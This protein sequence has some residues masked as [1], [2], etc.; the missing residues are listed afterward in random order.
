MGIGQGTRQRLRQ[1]CA[2]WRAGWPR[3]RAP[4]ATTGAR[5]TASTAA[6][7]RGRP[8]R[9]SPPCWAACATRP[10]VRA[11]RHA[12]LA[13]LPRTWYCDTAVGGIAQRLAFG[14]AVGWACCATP[15]GP[16][17]LSSGGSPSD[18][19]EPPARRGPS[20]RC[21]CCMPLQPCFAARA[22]VAP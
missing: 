13:R 16:H 1:C 12:A 5:R 22:A 14:M 4:A 3:L 20:R 15:A 2:S 10:R 17:M 8:A 21:A 6:T 7:A 11:R 18:L 9:C 19:A